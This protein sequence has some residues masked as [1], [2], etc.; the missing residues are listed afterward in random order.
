MKCVWLCPHVCVLCYISLHLLIA[1]I[2]D[3][4]SASHS[5]C[6]INK[7]L[8]N[9][10]RRRTHTHTH[11]SL[12]QSVNILFDFLPAGDLSFVVSSPLSLVPLY[13]FAEAEH[14]SPHLCLCLFCSG[15]TVGGKP[16]VQPGIHL[17]IL[18][19]TM[20]F[21]YIFAA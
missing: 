21:S 15:C 19:R 11:L 5:V 18:L 17:C 20:Q 12:L 13:V 14:R 4:L 3:L 9:M 16:N 1:L 6:R 10:K 7:L 2:T 8:G